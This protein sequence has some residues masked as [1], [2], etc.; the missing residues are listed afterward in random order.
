MEL[1]KKRLKRLWRSSNYMA[2]EEANHYRIH[3]ATIQAIRHRRIDY[4]NDDCECV[5]RHL[6]AALHLGHV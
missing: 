3:I 6:A 4:L 5:R 2:P 1:V